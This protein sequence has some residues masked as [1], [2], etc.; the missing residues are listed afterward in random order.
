ML[1]HSVN[2]TQPLPLPLRFSPGLDPQRLQPP[3]ALRHPG[4]NP[5]SRIKLASLRPE[6]SSR[7]PPSTALLRQPRHPQS[8]RHLQPTNLL[9]AI[10]PNH[11]QDALA[12]PLCVARF[13]QRLRLV[14]CRMRSSHKL[15]SCIKN[16]RRTPVKVR[17]IRKSSLL[18]RLLCPSLKSLSSRHRKPS[19]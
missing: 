5:L 3:L 7:L 15:T 6:S 13:Y 9:S 8:I 10:E 12:C 4:I 19:L 18:T 2:S 1:L 17:A 11:F 16:L 14:P